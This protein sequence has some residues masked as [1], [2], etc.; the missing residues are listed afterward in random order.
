M[1]LENNDYVYCPYCGHKNYVEPADFSETEREQECQKCDKT[2]VQ[3][4]EFTVTHYTRP[5]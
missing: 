5:K 3:Y 4:Y 2:F 1:K